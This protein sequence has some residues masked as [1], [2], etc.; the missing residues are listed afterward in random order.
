MHLVHP[1]AAADDDAEAVG[2]AGRDLAGGDAGRRHDHV[3]GNLARIVQRRVVEAADRQRVKAFARRRANGA[4]DAARHHRLVG[5]ELDMREAALAFR[6]RRRHAPRSAAVYAR[7]P[8]RRRSDRSSPTTPSGLRYM[9]LSG[10]S[11][12]IGFSCASLPSP[13]PDPRRMRRR[14]WQVDAAS[15]PPA[16]RPRR[17]PLAGDQAVADI[18]LDRRAVALFGIAEAAAIA[19]DDADDV[20]VVGAQAG[21]RR[22]SARSEPSLPQHRDIVRRASLPPSS[23]QGGMFSGC[24]RR[25]GSRCRRG[26]GSP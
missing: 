10:F 5:A 2:Q 4:N 18:V 20:V 3:A 22:R 25:S 9:I 7:A 21:A 26:R 24:S 23:A 11:L 17:S 12:V 19:G 14:A 16:V 13:A 1:F 8:C 6:Q 15:S